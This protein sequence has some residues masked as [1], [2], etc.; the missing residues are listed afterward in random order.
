MAHLTYY[1]STSTVYR[2]RLGVVLKSPVQVWEKSS[3]RQNLT[4]EIA[5][6]FFVERQILRKLG[7]HP[8]IVKSVHL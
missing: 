3:D 8:R 7:D 5:H 1:G 6:S 4:K 2:V